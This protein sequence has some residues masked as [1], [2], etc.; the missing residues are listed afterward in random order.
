MGHPS[1][2]PMA[3]REKLSPSDFGA[4]VDGVF[5]PSAGPTV[6]MTANSFHLDYADASDLGKDV[7]GLGNHFTNTGVT[8]GNGGAAVAVS[9]E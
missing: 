9:G 3:R 2:H 7:S 8:Q 6:Q 5:L 1:P 4:T